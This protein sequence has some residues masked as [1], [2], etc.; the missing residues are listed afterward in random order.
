MTSWTSHCFEPWRSAIVLCSLH[1]LVE[2]F[3]AEEIRL[4]DYL[5]R[6]NGPIDSKCKSRSFWL[7]SSSQRTSSVI[8]FG[9]VI[10]NAKGVD[11]TKPATENSELLKR[12]WVKEQQWFCPKRQKFA[13]ESLLC[14]VNLRKFICLIS[15]RVV[16]LLECLIKTTS[17]LMTY[18][19][20]LHY[21]GLRILT[22]WPMI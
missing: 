6:G 19:I 4:G 18:C 10:Q 14:W 22:L 13:L 16:T 20:S 2:I 17:S 12:H 11:P 7:W 8:V 3:P 15:E 9:R 21:M 5:T 1:E